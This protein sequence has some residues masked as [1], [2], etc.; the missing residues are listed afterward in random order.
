ME[1]NKEIREEIEAGSDRRTF[2]KKGAV[3]SV[4][5]VLS[6]F[7]RPVLAERCGLSGLTS[8]NLSGHE[9][10][11]CVLGLSPGAWKNRMAGKND[12][13]VLWPAP[14]T[15]STPYHDA[16]YG[17]AGNLFG[18]ASMYEVLFLTDYSVYPPGAHFVAALLN[19]YYFDDYVLS[20]ADVHQLWGEYL[21]SD[22]TTLDELGGFIDFNSFLDTTWT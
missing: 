16:T 4:P 1:E 22:Y 7:S 21:L 10:D 8:G 18:D 9:D 13:E 2:M 6:A 11:Q 15:L 20:V 14:F 19:A 17:F 12:K 3:V 5:L